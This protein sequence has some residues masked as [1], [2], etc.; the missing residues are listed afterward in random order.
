[1]IINSLMASVMLAAALMPSGPGTMTVTPRQPGTETFQAEMPGEEIQVEGT[2]LVMLPSVNG[3]QSLSAIISTEN[4]EVV[5]VD[6]GWDSDGDNL[7]DHIGNRGGYVN[8]WLV[9]HPHP[10]HAGAL[11][12]ILKNRRDDVD[13]EKIYYSFGT[14]DWYWEVSPGDAPFIDVLMYE[15][16]TLPEDVICDTIGRGYEI[17]LGAVHI[18]VMNDRYEL[19][20]DPVNNSSIAYMVDAGRKKVLFLGDMGYDGGYRLLED[21]EADLKADFVQVA[22]HGQNGVDKEVYE[23]IGARTFLWPTPKWLWDNDNGGGRDSGP[24]DTM[25]T[26]DWAKKMGIKRN[27]ATKDG[28][29][30]LRLD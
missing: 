26:R 20:S 16:S 6:G 13:I 12:H 1:M 9:T 5:V 27:Y 18:T 19:D 28:P 7:A 2:E 24:W 15:L 14:S 3:A 22:H 21:A 8:A 30:M 10:D 4:G 25:T 11:W 17:D 23:A 29:I